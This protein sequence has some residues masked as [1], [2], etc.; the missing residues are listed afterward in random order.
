MKLTLPLTLLAALLACFPAA[1]HAETV[2][3]YT[4]ES[5]TTLKKELT[6]TGTLTINSGCKLTLQRN[7]STIG[8]VSIGEGRGERS[9]SSC[10]TRGRGL[11]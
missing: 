9:T 10:V 6:V 7:T 5:N 1:S 3:H 4:V 11:E 8:S 2:E